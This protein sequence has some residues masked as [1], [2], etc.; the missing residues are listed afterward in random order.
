[1]WIFRSDMNHLCSEFQIILME[2]NE[3]Y[4]DYIKNEE[5]SDIERIPNK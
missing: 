3:E 4:L 1:M 2:Q 5:E